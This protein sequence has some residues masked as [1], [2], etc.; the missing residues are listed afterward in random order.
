MCR[1]HGS[2]FLIQAFSAKPE[3]SKVRA[4][5]CLFEM[6]WCVNTEFDPDEIDRIRQTINGVHD[7]HELRHRCMGDWAM[8]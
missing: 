7:L 8:H 2:S 3:L 6:S 5:C 1:R 4:F